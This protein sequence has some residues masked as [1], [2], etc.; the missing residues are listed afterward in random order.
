MTQADEGLA[1]VKSASCLSLRNRYV[2]G[3]IGYLLRTAVIAPFIWVGLIS[4]DVQAQSVVDCAKLHIGLVAD[5]VLAHSIECKSVDGKNGRME[6]L[7]ASGAGLV[8]VTTI[9]HLVDENESGAIK[10]SKI[11]DFVET[12]RAFKNTTGWT[13]PTSRAGFE[14]RSFAGQLRV[15]PGWKASCISFSRYSGQIGSDGYRHQIS[16]F[17][18]FKNSGADSPWT[19]EEID[20]VLGRLKYD[21]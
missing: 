12:T 20:Y 3:R 8:S 9:I 1:L 16:G 18:C 19:E 13:A 4:P 6:L 5:D 11:E 15:K 14:V 7:N 17:T 2:R 10:P 21:F